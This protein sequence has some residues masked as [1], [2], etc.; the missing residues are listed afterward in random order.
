MRAIPNSVVLWPSDGVSTYKLVKLMANYE[1]GIPYMKSTRSDAPILYDADQTFTLGGCKV[2]RSSG[3]DQAC[4]VDAGITV[5]EA[6]AAY[7]QLKEQGIMVSVIDLYSIKPLD[8]E[9]VIK[10]ATTSQNRII[11][12]EDHYPEGG[13]GEAVVSALRDT[14]IKIESLAVRKLDRK[15]VV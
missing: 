14:A 10:T 4:I 13:L 2:L 8:H 11:T 6:L 7:E 5:H 12:V 1:D 9:T 3:N 15:S